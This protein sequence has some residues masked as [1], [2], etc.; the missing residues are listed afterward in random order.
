MSTNCVADARG[1]SLT[2]SSIAGSLLVLIYF[3]PIYFQAV[4]GVSAIDSGLRNLALIIPVCT[5][6]LK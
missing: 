3:L 2:K 4:Q 1:S 5:H 6:S